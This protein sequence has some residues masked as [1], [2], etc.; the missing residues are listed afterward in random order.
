MS[1]LKEYWKFLMARKKLWLYPLLLA[2]GL[3]ILM[4][5]LS[6]GSNFAPIVYSIF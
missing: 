3:F 5:I 4:G 6:E 1:F 2:L